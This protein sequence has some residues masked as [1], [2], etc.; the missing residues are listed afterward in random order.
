LCLRWP[1]EFKVGDKNGSTSRTKKISDSDEYGLAPFDASK[2]LPKLTTWDA[3]PS[4]AEVKNIKPLLAH[5]Q[6][7][8]NAAGSGLKGTQLMVFFL[9]RRIQPLQARV[10]KLWTYAGYPYCKNRNSYLS[11]PFLRLHAP[12]ATGTRLAI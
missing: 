10:S 5:I 3:L 7:L 6:E 8:K 12:L 1:S 2:G 11:G 4:E 9:Q